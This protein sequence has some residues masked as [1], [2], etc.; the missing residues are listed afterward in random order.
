[1]EGSAVDGLAYIRQAFLDAD[2]S[3]AT[4]D[5]L[6]ESWRPGTRKQY[7]TY[8]TQFLEFASCNNIHLKHVQAS[9]VLEFLHQLFRR[10][11]GYSAINTARSAISMLTSITSE[12][13]MG[14]QPVIKRFMKAVFNKRPALPR[15]QFIWD[16]DIVLNYIKKQTMFG[17]LSLKDLTLTLAMLLALASGQR[18]QTLQA[19]DLCDC[20][21]SPQCVKFSVSAILKTSNVNKQQPQITLEKFPEEPNLCAFSALQE[22]L[23]RT[24]FL[25][26]NSTKLFVSY[27]KPHSP[28]SKAT[29]S[30]WIKTLMTR[31]GIDTSLFKPH[32]TRSA[33][34]SK[35]WQKDT[36][37]ETIMRAAHWSR[38]STFFKFYNRSI[39]TAHSASLL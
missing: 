7:S 33:A 24:Q 14:S 23:R 1:M 13:L 8:L 15:Y 38:S 18:C 4:A 29:F 9:H 17:E 21:A 34:T 25:R 10:G 5:F 2:I 22:Y 30:R 31:A 3:Q 19:L 35:A 20:T 16:T 28:V 36:P 11:L 6:M 32:S 26:N 37:L 12:T 27:I 39:D